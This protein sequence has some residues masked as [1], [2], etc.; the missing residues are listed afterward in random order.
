MRA[1]P[2]L[3]AAFLLSALTL[4]SAASSKPAAESPY[5]VLAQMARV[6]VLV[7]HEYVDP[8][9]RRRLAEGAIKGMVAELD[10]HSAYMPPEDYAIFQADTDGRFGGIG[11]EVDFGDDGIKVIAP[12]EGSPAERA[13]VKSGDR[14][15]AIDNQSV[16]GK[17]PEELVRWMRGGPGTK[18]TISVRR[19]GKSELIYFKLTREIIEVSSVT[20]TLMDGEIGY[21]RLKQ[22]QTGTHG[23]LLEAVARLR[24][25][26]GGPLAGVLLD[27]RNNPGG[28][29]SEATAVAD[30]MLDAGVVFT[31]RHR[32]RVVDEVKATRGGALR[33]G[34]LVVLVNEYSAS[35]AELVAG[36][37]QDQRRATI[38]GAKTFGKGSVQ[39][40]IDLPGGAGMRLTSMRYYTP[41]GRAIQ[42][43]GIEPDV[44]V[45]A[46]VLP[47][48]SFG[49][50]RESDLENHLPAEGKARPSTATP[51]SPS[52]TD[53]QSPADTHLGVGR[54]IPKNPTLGADVALSV[55]Y[56][57][58]TGVMGRR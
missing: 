45:E 32:K 49:V 24:A 51:P 3:T 52:D 13:G 44:Q 46:G 47:D 2:I 23:E 53:A 11:V 31:T 34:P 19:Q 28:L 8:V 14:I 17:S 4:S 9:E 40:I 29:V 36:A 55:A 35:A 58:V 30:E 41:K 48:K 50:V 20:E 15:V 7:E 57:I 22:F 6:L 21:L 5:D 56:Q 43:Q 26:N 25:E 16:R 18:V 12:I 38:V 54:E 33:R 37:L 1:R 27:M 10:P 42:A 39:T